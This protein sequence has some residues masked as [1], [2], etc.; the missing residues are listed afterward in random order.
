[1]AETNTFFVQ[2]ITLIR[3][4]NYLFTMIKILKVSMLCGTWLLNSLTNM[5]VY[6]KINKQIISLICN[7]FGLIQYI[8]QYI[9]LE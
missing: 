8:I 9:L 4:I 3:S 2:I 6:F 7:Y 1:M 5:L